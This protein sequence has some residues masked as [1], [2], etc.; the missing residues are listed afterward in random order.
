MNSYYQCRKRKRKT[1]NALNTE[2]NFEQKLLKL[3]HKL[4]NKTYKPGKSICFIVTYPTPREI[5]AADFVDRIVH[6]LLVSYLEPIFEKKFIYHSFACRKTKGTHLAVDSLKKF[7]RK[8]T[9]D[10][11]SPAYYLQTDISAFFMSIKKE[12]LYD[13]IKKQ[14]KNAEILWLAEIIIFHDPTKNFY[15]KGDPKL[16]RL[17]PKHKSLFYVNNNQ[18]LPIGNLTS[19]FFANVYLNELDQFIKHKLKAKY[20]LRYADDFI[21][22]HQNSKQL[23]KWKKQIDIFL[24][25]ELHLKLHPK[26]SIQQSI[27]RGINFSGFIIKP[28]YLLIRRRTVNNFKNKLKEL[29]NHKSTINKEKVLS[30]IN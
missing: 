2:I 7:T 8:I 14:T 20:Y 3:E 9:Q 6:H 1:V 25:K 21:L 17:V 12:I 19:Q 23:S 4:Q 29:N 22:I 30:V 13:L 16:N 28:K 27:Y 24:K 5:F 15:Y 18:G 26:K 10:F 11:S